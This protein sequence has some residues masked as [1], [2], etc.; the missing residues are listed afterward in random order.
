MANYDLT[1][2]GSRVQSI[3]DT[4][5]ELRDAG[6]I[7]RGEATPSTVPGTPTE[8]VAYIGGPGTYTNFGSSITVGAGC[9]CVFKY[10]GS[11]W[12][13]QVINTGLSDAISSEAESR[14]NADGQLQ[15]AIS[16]I[17]AQIGNGYVYAGVAT[18]STEPV[19]GK[20]FYL[21]ITAG[22]YTNFEDSEETPLAVTAGINILKN[23]GTGW[24]LDQVIAIDADP[25]QGSDNLV[26]SGGVLNSIIQNGPAFDLSAYNAQGGVLA[27]YADLSAALTA[28]NALPADFK[29]GGMSMKFVLSSDNKYVQYRL[30]AD[31]WS[32]AVAD[33][34][35]VD[36]E[37]TA[38]SENLVKSGGTFE[39]LNKKADNNRN[40]Y[41]VLKLNGDFSEVTNKGVTFSWN[42]GTCHLTNEASGYAQNFLIYRQN[43]NDVFVIGKKYKIYV[44]TDDTDVFF[45][46]ICIDSSDNQTAYD[47]STDGEFIVPSGF[48][49]VSIGVRVA[50]NTKTY[51]A[52]ITPTIISEPN[53][54]IENE[55]NIDIN[56]Q[57]ISSLWSGNSIDMIEKYGIFDTV[58]NNG[59]VF[60][61]DRNTHICHAVGT[62]TAYAN[63]KII[64][65]I[66]GLPNGLKAG[67][68]YNI[69]INND[70]LRLSVAYYNNGVLI[71]YVNITDEK[72][73]IPN[74]CDGVVIVVTYRTNTGAV[75]DYFSVTFYNAKTNKELEKEKADASGVIKDAY[76]DKWNRV[77]GLTQLEKSYFTDDIGT[78]GSLGWCCIFQNI[79][80]NGGEVLHCLC[81]AFANQYG[82]TGYNNQYAFRGYVFY[83]KDGNVVT[84]SGNYHIG[85]L[86]VPFNAVT[87][88]V[89]FQY[90]TKNDPSSLGEAW[91]T[92]RAQNAHVDIAVAKSLDSNI[93]P[94]KSLESNVESLKYTQ[95]HL[96]AGA[97]YVGARKPCFAFI[98]DVD[99][100]YNEEMHD[101]F[102]NHG[103]PCGFAIGQSIDYNRNPVYVYQIW[104]KQG[105]EIIAHGR[106]VLNPN[107][108]EYI[109][110]T[111]QE[112]LEDIQEQIAEMTA[113]GFVID[114]FVG[115]NGYVDDSF[116]PIIKRYFNAAYTAAN[117]AGSQESCFVYGID[118]PYRLWRY[119]LEGS[120]LVQAKAAV[121]RAISLNTSCIFYGHATQAAYEAGNFTPSN[122]TTLIEYIQSL[123]CEIKRPYDAVRDMFAVRYDDLVSE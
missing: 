118:H 20:V 22:T 123:G 14:A 90:Q 72:F 5:D 73:T 50:D 83:D 119:S 47:F 38:G 62:L 69:S 53:E 40:F 30:M 61:W 6:Y 82:A 39:Q 97:P 116:M 75:D 66:N 36:G 15:N 1:Y 8:R 77:E 105:F 108:S 63:I 114:E 121:D 16:A 110:T 13:N 59:V 32:T 98:L 35:G 42:N 67:E 115:K 55:T 46:I 94:L 56:N 79:P 93:E 2:E 49:L 84:G 113:Q 45:R 122:L 111:Y 27:T 76:I 37:P 87:V 101:V 12:S 89:C 86:Y 11:A 112:A 109:T 78:I 51:D 26:K 117:H 10:T 70:S 43:I 23:T 68:T 95:Q 48:A 28:L 88:S 17:N 58:E 7:F 52:Y 9:I 80:V 21:A 19:S 85:T 74:N 92:S 34:Q 25:T 60:T 71:T 33:W 65:S 41:D 120:T 64:D 81:E 18:P 100:T 107:D 24:V 106:K 102:Y 44:S 57:N 96:I 91:V 31:A 104:Q 103:V 4:G 29:K 3:L 54:V 99:A